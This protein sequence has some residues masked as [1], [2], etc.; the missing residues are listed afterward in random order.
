MNSKNVVDFNLELGIN[1][2]ENMKRSFPF[3]QYFGALTG[4]ETK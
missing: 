2:N 3:L 4:K 1:K